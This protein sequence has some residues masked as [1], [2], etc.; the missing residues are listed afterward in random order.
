VRTRMCLN[1]F[2]TMSRLWGRSS[3]HWHLCGVRKTAIQPGWHRLSFVWPPAI[4]SPRI[5][6]WVAMRFSTPAKPQPRA[7]T[8]KN[9]GARSA[10]PQTSTLQHPCPICDSEPRFKD[11]GE[12]QVFNAK[13][14][15]EQKA[16]VRR[17]GIQGT[18]QNRHS[19]AVLGRADDLCFVLR[20]VLTFLA[21]AGRRSAHF[22]MASSAGHRD[23]PHDV[24]R[25]ST[26][27]GTCG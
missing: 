5:S 13:P 7:P 22:R 20:V 14:P 25:Y 6:C 9:N 26:L 24:S 21:C 8:T 17:N 1:C 10:S 27:G 3:R 15:F 11:V 2:R 4:A 23:C 16:A 18:S 12:T 19:G